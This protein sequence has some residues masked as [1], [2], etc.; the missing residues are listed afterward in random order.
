M[1]R[2]RTMLI[3]CVSLVSLLLDSGLRGEKAPTPRV[4]RLAAFTFDRI[5]VMF[6]R[7]LVKCSVQSVGV[8]G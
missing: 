4:T 7:S 6:L 8:L 2:L 5:T 1:L 3:M